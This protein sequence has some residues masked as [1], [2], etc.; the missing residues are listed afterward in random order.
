MP[1]WIS[2]VNPKTQKRE[3]VYSP[4]EREDPAGV[5]VVRA[6]RSALSERFGIRREDVPGFRTEPAP[7]LPISMFEAVARD[8]MD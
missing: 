1:M 4:Y 3:R 2:W 7:W 6:S 8:T 5:Q